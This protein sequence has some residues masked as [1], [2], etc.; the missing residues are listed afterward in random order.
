MSAIHWR[1]TIILPAVVTG[2]ECDLT[3][4]DFLKN[5]AL[6]KI[7]GP[8]RHCEE[9]HNFLSSKLITSRTKFVG[10]VARTVET[11]NILV[12]KPHDR[13]WY[14]CE[15]G[16]TISVRTALNPTCSASITVSA[17]VMSHV[18]EYAYHMLQEVRLVSYFIA[19]TADYDTRVI[20]RSKM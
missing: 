4:Y 16:R 13:Q 15:V 8:K 20:R 10:H 14:L 2:A 17:L 19:S 11:R 7:F 18:N 12:G 5:K 3:E 1:K 9:P 6:R